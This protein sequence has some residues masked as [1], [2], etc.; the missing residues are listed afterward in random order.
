MAKN[1]TVGYTFPIKHN[2]VIR[3]ARIYFS[4][5]NAFTF[6]KYPGMNP[7]ISLYGLDGLHQ[8]RDFTAF[9]IAKTYSVGANL[10]F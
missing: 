10:N 6:T 7:E 8:G 4:A 3:S 1:I 9:P 5:Q 2:S